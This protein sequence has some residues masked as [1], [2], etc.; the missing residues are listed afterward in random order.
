MHIQV[1]VGSV[2]R[3]RKAG[4]I[5]QWVASHV[6]A[7]SDMTVEIIDLR[8]WNLPYFDREI[9]PIAGN[10]VDPLQRRWAATISRGDGYLFICPEYNHGYPAPL[11]NAIDFIYAEWGHKPASIVSY[12]GMGGARSVEQLRLVLIEMRIAPLR[13]AV[14]LLNVGPKFDGLAFTGDGA[15]DRQVRVVLEE[16]RWWG[17]ALGHARGQVAPCPA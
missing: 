1:I 2:R 12:G 16:L 5:G 11:K 14:H 15:D 17:D 9:P 3:G 7:R 13:D 4:A 8:D 10:Y 6:A